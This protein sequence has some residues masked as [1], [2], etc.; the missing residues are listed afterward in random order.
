MVLGCPSG[1]AKGPAGKPPPSG[2]FGAAVLIREARGTSLPIAGSALDQDFP[3]VYSPNG[4]MR[5]AFLLSAGREVRQSGSI[6][7]ASEQMA[8]P[9]IFGKPDPSR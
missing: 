9:C 8:L 5:G 6:N 3:P 2:L 7:N 1:R 4:R